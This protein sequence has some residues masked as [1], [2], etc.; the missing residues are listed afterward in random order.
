ME[1]EDIIKAYA[2]M[3]LNNVVN[4]CGTILVELKMVTRAF[5]YG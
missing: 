3:A 1:K 4:V 2:N 5:L